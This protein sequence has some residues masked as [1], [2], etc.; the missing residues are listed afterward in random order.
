VLQF[1]RCLESNG[2][3]VH[4]FDDAAGDL[5]HGIS[6]FINILNADISKQLNLKDLRGLYALQ[7]CKVFFEGMY[8]FSKDLKQS[9]GNVKN[10]LEIAGKLIHAVSGDA[11]SI[12]WL[13][14][15]G[16]SA[17]RNYIRNYFNAKR[18]AYIFTIETFNYFVLLE[19]TFSDNQAR[20]LV[21]QVIAEFEKKR[22]DICEATDWIWLYG[23]TDVLMNIFG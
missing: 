22:R 4:K 6:Q 18:R 20:M 15:K 23:I 1:C 2:G 9:E 8:K 11:A 16:F 19:K 3:Y 17:V 7:T 12:A 13:I 21:G 14:E 10:A 5:H